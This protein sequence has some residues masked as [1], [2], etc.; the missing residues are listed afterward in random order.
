MKHR[1]RF[2]IK[3]RQLTGI[4]LQLGLLLTGWFGA[5]AQLSHAGFREVSKEVGVVYFHQNPLREGGGVTFFDY[6]NDGWE[7]LFITGGVQNNRLYR[8]NGDKTFT[9]VSEAAGFEF[10]EERIFSSSGVIAGDI[11]NDGYD[12][13]FISTLVAFSN[14][15]FLNNRNGTFTDISVEARLFGGGNSHG[16]SFIDANEDGLLDIYV[17][18]YVDQLRFIIDDNEVITGFG[19]AC[20]ANFL[21]I[22]NGDLTFTES[23]EAYG[24]ADVGCGQAVATT[25]INGDGHMDLYVANDFGF[26]I[27]PNKAYLNLR[28]GF[29]F[30]PAAPSSGLNSNIYSR[31]IAIG[32][33]DHNQLQDYYVSNIG[34]NH[35]WLQEI[36]SSFVEKARDF[37]ITNG[38][39]GEQQVTSWGSFFFDYDHDL[40][41]D[42]FVA[43]GYVTDL[44]LLDPVFND[45][46]KLFV[47]D[48]SGSFSS[49][50][51]FEAIASRQANRGAAYADYD[52]D[53]DLDIY[54]AV[55]SVSD[56]PNPFGSFYENQTNEGNWLIIKLVGVTVNRNA[57]GAA[58]TLYA[59][60]QVLEREL[61]SGGSYGSQS[62]QEL[63][64][65]LADITAIDSVQVRWGSGQPAEMLYN[66]PV[67]Q[68]VRIV[69]GNGEFEVR[70]CPDDENCQ[71]LVL[72]S[73]MSNP[74]IRVYPIPFDQSFTLQT[75][76]PLKSEQ[77]RLF[78]LNGKDITSD[79]AISQT[80]PLQLKTTALPKGM[81]LLEIRDGSFSQVERII[82]R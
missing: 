12:D 32:D 34:P 46:D 13:L 55:V 33:A 58:V 54:S 52:R 72:N 40:D 28:P 48:G 47:N 31:G 8:N 42:L 62:S 43:N 61:Y 50:L 74:T 59:D 30:T 22:N 64:F 23:A 10:Q 80:H 37:G 35:F 57:F 67:N 18:N 60:G 19:H 16:A 9:D 24:V 70:G 38:V 6:D 66:A 7:D 29:E 77:I 71:D 68:R 56:V 36:S 14:R 79:I 21:F 26:W 69:Q 1:N 78:D 3:Q 5:H 27:L 20:A 75:S 76:Q 39:L 82:K 41:L 11:N 4:F 81:Y 73:E 44:E 65:G 45:P 25:D 2:E 49:S 17:A 63:H 53:G 15:L 51:S